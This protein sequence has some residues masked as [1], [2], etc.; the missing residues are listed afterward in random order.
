M[1]KFFL[2]LFTVVLT[3]NVKAE[4]D[5]PL[6]P[7][8]S[9]VEKGV[10]NFPIDKSVTIC[11][12]DDRVLGDVNLFN[13]Y[14]NKMYGFSFPKLKSSS[15]NKGQINV[16]MNQEKD[17]D[18]YALMIDS[19]GIN[20]E[21]GRN[22]GAF[23]AF[24]TLMQLIPPA[25]EISLSVPSVK[26]I[27]APRFS[28]RGMHL[29][30]ARH[31]FKVESVKRFID[32][33]AFY[34][35]N[36]FHWHLTDD[37]GW[38][39]EI[40]KYPLLQTVSAWRNG[41]L[42]GHLF[43][44]PQ[45]YDTIKYG[46]FYTQDEIRDV[47][48][49]AAARH[50]T[51]IP[52]I[53]MPGHAQAVLAAYPELSCTGGKFEV[54]ETWGVYKDVFCPKEETFTFLQNV[55]DEVCELFP[56]KYIHI[57]GDECPKD[58][59]K[60]CP[61]CQE[62]IKKEGLK[63]END[64]Q[65]YF[66]D[67]I[68]G[69]LKTKNKRAI[70]WDEILE[71]GLDS[72]AVIMSWRGYNGGANGAIKGHDVVM[73][74]AGYCYFDMYQ[75]RNTDGRIAIGGYLPIEQVYGFEPVPDVLNAT[76]A[77]QILGTQGNVWT[78]YIKDDARLEEMIFPRICA[79]AEVQWSQRKNRDFKDFTSRLLDH[80]QL[81]DFRKIHCSRAVFDISSRVIPN[82][83]AGLFVELHTKFPDGKIYYTFNG[84]D[85]DLKS[86]LYTDR[87]V[88]DQSLFIKAALF[89]SNR[90]V[91]SIFTQWVKIN[92]ST[93][94]EI[95]LVNQPHAEYSKGG[96]FSLVDGTMGT[97]PWI[98]TEWLGFQGKDLDA[99]IDLGSIQTLA[100]VTVDVLK[101]EEGLSSTL[102]S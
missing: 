58:R 47:I 75:S 45:E 5:L 22:G 93:G 84:T 83:S 19:N 1:T 71:E 10:G 57:G 34:K 48:Q 98:P 23:Y 79:L 40:K 12:N 30:V 37:Q 52:E 61:H 53:E 11:Y 91:G 92:K 59:W 6:V 56:G 68:A 77:S 46:G 96:A 4:T 69:Y 73:A 9:I 63:D 24:Q 32:F 86:Q 33:L 41:T 54:G 16:A 72:N 99:T 88:A 26:I 25:R 80:F 43:D 14:M 27:D 21:A 100:R 97:L 38:R 39:I 29:D 42:K 85:P 31:F 102:G 17:S 65:R 74:P 50:I 66:T 51:I 67:R 44:Q 76:Q 49:Y 8:P 20:I 94:K 55:L 2:T 60:V 35:M 64:L 13:E 89:R 90:K 78:E 7:I 101:D 87:I 82:G 62:L 15:K 3:M 18:S 36:I 28:Y 81:I 95:T 70:G